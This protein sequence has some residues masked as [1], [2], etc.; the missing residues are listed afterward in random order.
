MTVERSRLAGRA[1]MGL[2]ALALLLF[3]QGAFRRSYAVVAIPAAITVALFSALAFW[4]GY[5]M[6]VHD[7]DHP[8]D[9]PAGEDIPAASAQSAG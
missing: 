1:L 4:V 3:L 6:A 2:S 5:T 8:P 9:Y 7:W